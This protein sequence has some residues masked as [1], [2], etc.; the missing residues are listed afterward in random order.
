M[1]QTDRR[2]GGALVEF[3]LVSLI[4]YLLFAATIEFGRLIFAAQ[5]LQDVARVA[6]RELAVTPLPAAVTFDEALALPAVRERVWDSAQLIVNATNDATLEA[7]FAALPLVNRALRPLFIPD[8]IG[9]T[10][11][12][13]YP[14]ALVPD[15]TVPVWGLRVMIPKEVPG[16]GYVM[17]SV[18]QEVR[19]DPGDPATGPFSATSLAVPNSIA[20]V[21]VQ[22]PFQAASMS[23]FTPQP[24]EPS[25]APAPTVGFVV[26]APADTPIG[27]YTG[28]N[29]LGAQAAFGQKV[30]PY[31][32]ILTGQSF[33]RREV[34]E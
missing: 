5:V 28:E 33:F 10:S 2:Q 8:K 13:R 32:R 11:V 14:G 19:G 30:R 15:A 9:D 1:R 17:R 12:L 27:T 3:A 22:Y 6:A 25:G 20:A 21:L 34:L 18:L 26:P 31:R 23:A 4:F 16:G 29:G 7:G 24:P